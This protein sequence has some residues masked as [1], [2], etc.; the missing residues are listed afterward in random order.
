VVPT[1]AMREAEPTGL[2]NAS[3]PIPQT[4]TPV[5]QVFPF[6]AQG[7]LDSCLPDNAKQENGKVVKITDGDTIDVAINDAVHTVRYIGMDTPEVN[8]AFYQEASNRNADLVAGKDIVLVKD[9]SETD[10]YGRLLRYVFVKGVFV[11]E[12][13]VREGF[14]YAKDYPPD[15]SCSARFTQAQGVAQSQKIGLWFVASKSGSMVLDT[16]IPA[17]SGC[18]QGCTKQEAG[19]DIKGNINSEGVKIYH[20]PSSRSYSATK[21]DPSKG[22]RWFCTPEE[23]E[24]NGWRAP[25]N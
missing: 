12:T 6:V 11:N 3:N 23:A 19:C 8:D 2:T 14:A 10:R 15:T 1:Y 18:P 17:A 9:S 7:K 16:V 24:A 20:T 4:K 13:L 21:I 25:R 22:E 5:K